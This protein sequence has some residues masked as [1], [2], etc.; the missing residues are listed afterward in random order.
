MMQDYGPVQLRDALDRYRALLSDNTARVRRE[1]GSIRRAYRLEDR[2]RRGARLIT[3]ERDLILDSI[4]W[5]ECELERCE[6]E[7]V[8]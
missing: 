3:A 2:G 1:F 4:G 7:G 6:A 5:I 8:A